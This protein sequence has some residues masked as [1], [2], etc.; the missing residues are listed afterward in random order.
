MPETYQDSFTIR[1]NTLADMIAY[2]TEQARESQWERTAVNNLRVEPLEENSWLCADT[3]AFANHV[4]EGAVKD[5]LKNLGLAVNLK[6]WYYPLRDTAYKSLLDRARINGTAL[7]KLKKRD[8]SNTLN[9]CLELYNDNALMLFRDQKVAA[10]HSGGDNDYAILPIDELME[11]INFSLDERFPGNAFESGYS[12]H[13]LTSAAWLLPDQRDDLLGTYRRT[14]EAQGKAGIA[15][16]LTPGIRFTTSDTGV[17][18]AKVSALLLGLPYPI[19]IGG[20]V[21]TEHRGQRKISDFQDS[22]SMLFAQFEN[23]VKRLEKLTAVYLDY[24]VNVMTAVCKHLS[25]PKKIALEAIGMY[26]VSYGGGMATAHDVFLAM[27]E[28]MFISKTENTPIS[29]MLQLEE[30]MARALTLN[31]P[32]FDTMKAVN[33]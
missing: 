3:S 12:D 13:S 18:S 27:Q 14:L 6:G 17:A 25:M 2:H 16:K 1:F 9:I 26:E 15:A 4:S 29:K 7:P 23:S 32:Q 31:W 28:I 8:L 10:I 21:A 5:T 30:S 11:S 19:S 33:W 24:P 22:L 20:M